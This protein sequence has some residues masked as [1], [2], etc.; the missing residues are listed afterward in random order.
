[1]RRN[2][3]CYDK[4]GYIRSILHINRPNQETCEATIYVA[5]NQTKYLSHVKWVLL[6]V[7]NE[8]ENS[9]VE[10]SLFIKPFFSMVEVKFYNGDTL[11][12]FQLY[13]DSLSQFILC[14]KF[15]EEGNTVKEYNSKKYAYGLPPVP[16][17][18]PTQLKL[19]L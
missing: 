11:F 5:A 10:N 9:I 17:M 6:K 8:K 16:E 15:E 1:M 14:K 3:V 13:Y 4:N 12:P 18:S 19:P 7:D 2:F